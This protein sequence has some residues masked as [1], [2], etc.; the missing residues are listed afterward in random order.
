MTAVY[1]TVDFRT[2]ENRTHIG[3]P[4]SGK[5]DLE[6][7]LHDVGGNDGPVALYV[8]ESAPERTPREWRGKV[9]GLARASRLP[10]GK[11]IH[12]YG[13]PDLD[14]SI[15]W[16]IG[17]PCE[18]VCRP[19]EKACPTLREIVESCG[20]PN[21]FRYHTKRLHLGSL[22]LD[23]FMEDAL[24]EH[25]KSVCDLESLTGAGVASRDQARGGVRV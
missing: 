8:P 6:E 23:A 17:F 20:T 7:M 13:Y 16:P 4:K 24:G 9:V 14:G 22:G 1:A 10:R 12:D 3:V 25:F 15:R 11:N 2:G 18:L 5:D 19:D 21:N